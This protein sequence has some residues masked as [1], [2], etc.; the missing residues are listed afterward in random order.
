MD[1]RQERPMLWMSALIL[2]YSKIP[3]ATTQRDHP[4]D[5]PLQRTPEFSEYKESKKGNA[6]SH[7]ERQLPSPD[8]AHRLA[9]QP[10]PCPHRQTLRPQSLAYFSGSSERKRLWGILQS[11][12]IKEM[13]TQNPSLSATG[14][15]ILP[16]GCF[17]L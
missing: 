16:R 4:T 6:G 2:K 17:L 3:E 9:S 11:R 12:C 14:D 15:Y 5:L 1:P 8:A 7:T 13:L 10:A